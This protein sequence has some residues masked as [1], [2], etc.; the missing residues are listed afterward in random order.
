MNRTAS[1]KVLNVVWLFVM[2]VTLLA[3]FIAESAEPGVWIVLALAA[4]TSLK[5]HLVIDYFMGMQYENQRLRRIMKAYFIV[6]PLA[7]V[8]VY[9]F[10]EVLV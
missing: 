1:I 2:A 4:T 5:G 6:I 7:A 8:V 10:P 3:A 9:L